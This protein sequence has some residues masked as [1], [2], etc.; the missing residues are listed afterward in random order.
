[1]ILSSQCN[2]EQRRYPVFDT[3]SQAKAIEGIH[4]SLVYKEEVD[5]NRV[6]ETVKKMV[7]EAGLSERDY[8]FSNYRQSQ[9]YPILNSAL[10][11]R[12]EVISGGANLPDFYNF[13][14][15][16][17]I[18]VC[19]CKNLP[20][21][22]FDAAMAIIRQKRGLV[23]IGTESLLQNYFGYFKKYNFDAI[24]DILKGL[25]PN[26]KLTPSEGT[27]L[28]AASVQNALYNLRTPE[29]LEYYSALQTLP[30]TAIKRVEL[31]V[32]ELRVLGTTDEAMPL[33]VLTTFI[34]TGL[35]P[36]NIELIKN[37]Y[38][39]SSDEVVQ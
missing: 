3:T 24:I 7:I 28:V 38:L 11:Y 13:H 18:A 21:D 26:I 17:E 5:I 8:D 33:D 36:N 9:L 37:K 2:V 19:A 4:R 32:Q 35:T 16:V 6:A 34:R 22:A 39:T 25:R 14:L 30:Q 29:R 15:A 27:I 12:D 31:V 10:N 1:M 20:Y 23:N